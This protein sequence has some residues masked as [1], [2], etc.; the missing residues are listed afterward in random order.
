MKITA[1]DI[2][3]LNIEL[4]SKKRNKNQKSKILDTIGT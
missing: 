4:N 3:I 2:R 1:D